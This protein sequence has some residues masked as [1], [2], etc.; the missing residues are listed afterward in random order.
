MS[1]LASCSS[2]DGSDAVE[3]SI[4]ASSVPLSTDTA[5]T[6]EAP[7]PTTASPS[8]ID[9]AASLAADVEAD[10]RGGAIRL[11]DQAQQDPFDREAEPAALDRRVGLFRKSFAEV[12]AN[13]RSTN[14][15]IRPNIEVPATIT[16]EAP[17]ALVAPADDVVDM[18]ICEVAT[19]MLV[20]VGARPNGADAI[21]NTDIVANRTQVLHAER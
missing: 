19:W 10:F 11:G 12:L 4:D 3:T 16:V 14:C 17:A 7:T 21:V 2:G 9:P 15:A 1:V 20:E 8:T 13:Y 5:A 6:T 18:Q